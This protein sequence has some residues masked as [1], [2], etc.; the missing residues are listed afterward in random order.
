MPAVSP[1][2]CVENITFT[3]HSSCSDVRTRV[4]TKDGVSLKSKGYTWREATP[5]R[6]Q[7]WSG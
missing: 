2:V 5:R 3:E 7:T 6:G 1:L 4:K